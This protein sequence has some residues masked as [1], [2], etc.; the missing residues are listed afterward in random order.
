MRKNFVTEW[1]KYPFA[2]LLLPL[3]AGIVLAEYIR[4]PSLHW[5]I[6]SLQLV[7]FSA[8]TFLVYYTSYR[9]RFLFGIVLYSFLFLSGFALTVLT[10]KSVRTEFPPG[11]KL[12]T[13]VLMTN[14]SEKSASIQC[15]AY[16]ISRT[17]SLLMEDCK[18]YAVLSFRKSAAARSLKAGDMIYYKARTQSP[19]PNR[20]PGSFN[21]ADYLRYQGISGTAYIPSYA[22][23]YE[24]ESTVRTMRG[25]LPL[26]VRLVLY[27]RELRNTLL[28]PYHAKNEDKETVSVLSALTLGDVSGLPQQLKEDYSVAGASHILALSGSHLA[29]LYAILELLFSVCLYRWRAG[30][31]VGKTAIILIIWN[32]VFLA[33]CQPSIIRAA[34]MY[35]LLVLASFFSRKAVSLNSLAAAA[36]FMLLADPYSLFDVGF[37]LSFLAVMGI[38][39]FNTTLYKRIRTPYKT[40]NYFISVMTVSLAVQLIS[41]PVVL[42]YFSAFP[43]YF[44]LTNLLV[45]PL[46]SVVLLLALAG[47]LI[48]FLFPGGAIAGWIIEGLYLLVRI[49]NEGVRW[50]AALPCASLSLPG[51]S[52]PEVL[53]LYVMLSFFLWKQFVTSLSRK[54]VVLVLGLIGACGLFYRQAGGQEKSCLLFYENRRCPAAHVVRR[55]R[56]GVLFPAWKDSLEK[57]MTYIESSFWKQKGIPYPQ[58]VVPEDHILHSDAGNIL[59]LKD[60]YWTEHRLKQRLKIDY[61]WICRGFYGD[62]PAALSS[63]S[64]RFVILDASLSE[65]YRQVYREACAK[66]GLPFHD[67]TENGSLEIPL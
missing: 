35:T 29:V 49:Q 41:F 4:P 37:Q 8:L 33:G 54:Y 12:Y 62:L 60:F 51:I 58:I 50:I 18:T 65:K 7:C 43:L 9:L 10:F 30:R 52:F 15:E 6:Y 1:H 26:S 3:M 38:L 2:G 40:V 45:V 53:W 14:A 34:I 59:L 32:F 36:F 28:A 42:Y 44:L 25:K 24:A 47:F 16:L 67:M 23:G 31:I 64:V 39:F 57:G 13:A 11:N 61:V 46:S 66:A 27:F 55:G 19:R 17:D 56:K 48:Q 20:N 22:W 63:F 5:I 21:Y